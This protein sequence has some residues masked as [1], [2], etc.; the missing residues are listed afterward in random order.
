MLPDPIAADLAASDRST[1]QLVRV[2]IEAPRLSQRQFDLHGIGLTSYLCLRKSKAAVPCAQALAIIGQLYGIERAARDRQLDAHARQ[3]LR[4]EQ[5]RPI[6]ENLCAYLQEQQAAALPKSPLGTAI[7]YVLRNWVALT[8]Y[9]EDGGSRSTTTGQSRRYGRLCLAAK[10]GCS[11]GAKERRTTPP[12][13]VRWYR[14]A[15]ICRSIRSYIC[16]M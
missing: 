8:R 2:A 14:S 3:R 6:L 4:Q 1:S 9:A 12:F 11:R 5:A 16:A 7:G 10:I 13:C 15:N